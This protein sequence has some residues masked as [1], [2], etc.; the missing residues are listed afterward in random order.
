LID[1]PPGFL[2]EIAEGIAGELG[3]TAGPSRVAGEGW[4]YEFS[5]DE[6]GV[7]IG[8]EATEEELEV[9][10]MFALALADLREEERAKQRMRELAT[11]VLSALKAADRLLEGNGC[12]AASRG[13]VAIFVGRGETAAAWREALEQLGPE[14]GASPEEVPDERWEA[15]DA[16]A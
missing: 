11:V 1:A 9:E 8:R 2:H 16:D 6:A 7:L 13:E 4:V 14:Y 5:P 12:V 10:K 3:R 15:V